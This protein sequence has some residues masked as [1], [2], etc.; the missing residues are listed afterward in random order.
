MN[1]FVGAIATL[2][3]DWSVLQWPICRDGV[4]LSGVGGYRDQAASGLSWL[5]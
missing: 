4:I 3:G 2:R 5:L 1:G